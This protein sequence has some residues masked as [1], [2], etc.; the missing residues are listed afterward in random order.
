M[1]KLKTIGI[2]FALSLTTSGFALA[3]SDHDHNTQ[4][5]GAALPQV[6]GQS[7]SMSGNQIQMMQKMMPLMMGMH[8]EMIGSEGM[9]MNGPAEKSGMMMDRS[10]MR[11]MMG[12]GMIDKSSAKDTAKIL[13]SRLAEFD[14]NG[15]GNLTLDEFE[16]LH[17]AMIIET[18]VDQFQHLDADGDG[19]ITKT[20]VG[21]LSQ[22]MQ[23]REMKQSGNG[24]MGGMPETV[25]GN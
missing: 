19:K 11:M 14:T 12:S 16:T 7:G 22:R 1:E 5:S 9:G 4:V 17:A 2:V 6:G 24:M 20:E 23:M 10:M 25:E 21:A 8:A 13:Q 15:D 3:Q 18:T